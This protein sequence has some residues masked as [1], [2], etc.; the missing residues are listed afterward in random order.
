MPI[1]TVI[2]NGNVRRLPFEGTPLVSEVL[3]AAGLLIPHPCG[4]KGRC[5]KCAVHITG[6]ISA[7]TETEQTRGVRLSCLTRLLGDATLTL[8]DGTDTMRIETD[9]AA[10][11]LQATANGGF[12]A[13]IDIGTTTVAL[14]LYDLACG[15]CVGTAAAPN[16]QTAVAAD[17]MGRIEAAMG[18]QRSRLQTMILDTVKD[19]LAQASP[20]GEIPEAL[21]V[22]LTGNTTMLYL[23]C[24]YDPTALSRAPFC[25]DHLF[26]TEHP[27]PFLARPAYLPPCMNAFVGADITCAVLAAGMCEQAQTALLCDIG[28]NGELALLKDGTLYVT[29]TAAGPAFEGAGIVCGCGSIAGAIDRVWTENGKL[30][31]HTI[32]EAPAVGICGSGVIDAVAAGL[33]V[34]QI[35]ESGAMDEPMPLAGGIALYPQDVRAVQLAKAAIAAGID[36]LL[37]LSRTDPEEIAVCYVAGGFG[38]HLNMESAAA[39]GLL[40]REFIPRAR[41]LGNAALSGAAMTLAQPTARPHLDEIAARAKHINLGGNSAFSNHY[42]NRMIFGE[43]E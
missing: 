12:G 32:G 38:S 43:D 2:R 26:G 31:F 36:T 34:G 40:P 29:S 24:G 42:I 37:E 20:D 14:K 27:L 21:S 4:G 30:H 1:L 7:P 22:T 6:D 11:M 5:G 19:L 13:A 33:E 16:P 41:I 15:T 35:D 23:L 28:T 17:V 3:T 25:A 10:P 39:I 8:P 9:T 18:G